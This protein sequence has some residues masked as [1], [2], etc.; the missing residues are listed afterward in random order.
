MDPALI[1][2]GALFLIWPLQYRRSMRKIRSRVLERGGDVDR[3][4]RGMDRPWIRAMLVIA[5]V[6][7]AVLV[8]LG[9]TQ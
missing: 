2:A 3:L 1:T 6:A 9:A 5:P 7:G 8:V 4:N